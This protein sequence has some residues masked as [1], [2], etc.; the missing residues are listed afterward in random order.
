M[1]SLLVTY[2]ENNRVS[3]TH[4]IAGNVDTRVKYGYD[5]QG[6]LLNI[7]SVTVDTSA[8]LTST[9]RHLWSYDNDNRPLLMLKIKNGGDTIRVEMITDEQG[10]PAEEHWKGKGTDIETYYYYYNGQHR[11]TDIVRFN[12]KAQKLLP[13]FL[14]E[15]DA[16][17]RVNQVIQVP[18]GSS[19]YMVWQTTFNDKGLKQ[20]ETGHDRQKQLVGRM[21]YV[22]Q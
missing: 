8:Q 17:G 5:D 21:E 15:H 2:F 1:S 6:R 13:D 18:T 4:E 16:E 19:N 3:E 10:N 12:Q 22:Y 9:E 20:Q 14:F 7:T 11:L